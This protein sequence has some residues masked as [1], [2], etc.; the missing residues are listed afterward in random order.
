MSKKEPKK[1]ELTG[2][3]HALSTS[4]AFIEKYQKQI[5]IAVCAVVAIVL[6]VLAVNH[7]VIQPREAR[8]ESEMHRAQAHFANGAFQQALDGDGFETIGFRAIATEFRRT[9][10]GNLASAYA[11]IS[12]FR[13]GEYENAIHF[14]SRFRG[15]DSYLAVAV[16]GMIGDSYVQL[17][18]TQRAIRFFEKAG[19]MNNAVLSPIY[20]KKAG[21]AHESL[22]QYDRAIRNF[23]AIKNSFPMSLE[24]EDIERYIARVTR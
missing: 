16:T 4:E 24:A 11:G 22:G 20:L 17:G 9:S 15:R 21:L 12:Y 14:L 8:A 1:E 13:L 5:L 18:E 6:L 2:A 23:Q 3:E 19:A 7:F 10:S